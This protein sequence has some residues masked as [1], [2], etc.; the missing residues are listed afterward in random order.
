MNRQSLFRLA[1]SVVLSYATAGIGGALTELGP[2]Y[3]SLRQPEWKP[4]DV[5]FGVIWTLIFTLCAVS[6]W[7]AWQASDSAAKRRR[8]AILFGL[9]AALNIFW[10]AL[11]FKLQRPDWALMEV[12]FLW[13][14][15]VCLMVGL[16][17]LSRWASLLLLPYFF[18]VSIA[19][20]LNLQTVALNGPFV[21]LTAR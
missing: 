19:S 16:W 8:V 4:P 1:L 11:Y 6:A 2:W 12:V 15:I 9:N 3:F 20:V 17:R 5:A 14:S 18:W 21:G 10:S 7:L 13:F